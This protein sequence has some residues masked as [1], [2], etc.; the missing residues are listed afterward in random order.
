[1]EVMDSERYGTIILGACECA[2][3][4]RVECVY[5]RGVCENVRGVCGGSIEAVRTFI[6]RHV[7]S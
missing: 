1:M 6:T 2:W 7:V 3:C 5:V 4:V